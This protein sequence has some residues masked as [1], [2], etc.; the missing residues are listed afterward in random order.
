M[1]DNV[2]HVLFACLIR[3][4][5]GQF[6]SPVLQRGKP[7]FQW[8]EGLDLDLLEDCSLFEGQGSD[9][10]FYQSLPYQVCYQHKTFSGVGV[11]RMSEKPWEK[12]W[13]HTALKPIPGSLQLYPGWCGHGRTSVLAQCLM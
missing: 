4:L 2:L 11:L 8:D 10:D 13:G 6:I 3:N 5:Q 7:K 9:R 12:V 1:Q